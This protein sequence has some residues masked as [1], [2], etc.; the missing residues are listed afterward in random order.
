MRWL[1]GPLVGAGVKSAKMKSLTVGQGQDPL[2]KKN[3][4]PI[5]GGGRGAGPPPFLP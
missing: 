2:L 3:L 1:G 5:R 4:F